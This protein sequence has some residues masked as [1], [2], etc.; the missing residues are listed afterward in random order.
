[1]KEPLDVRP[2]RRTS[3][4]QRISVNERDMLALP[5]RENRKRITVR[6]IP[7][8]PRRRGVSD[9]HTVSGGTERGTVQNLGVLTPR[10]GKDGGPTARRQRDPAQAFRWRVAVRTFN[11]RRAPRGD[12]RMC[13]CAFIRRCNS[14]CTVLSV[15]AVEIG[16]FGDY[17]NR[18]CSAPLRSRRV[19]AIHQLALCTRPIAAPP[20]MRR[21]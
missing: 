10:A 9:E 13:C 15:T 20:W 12:Q 18:S 5:G 2:G 16:R 11:I 17:Y 3:A 4:Y 6:T 14:Q 21:P 8:C 7:C 1:M 19:T